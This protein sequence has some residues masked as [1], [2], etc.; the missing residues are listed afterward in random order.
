[1]MTR[2]IVTCCL[3]VCDGCAHL[4]RMP[5]LGRFRCGIQSDWTRPFSESNPP[6]GCPRLPEL[7]VATVLRE[8]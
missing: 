3:G 7:A 8:L 2:E 1:M 6:P 4:L 5:I